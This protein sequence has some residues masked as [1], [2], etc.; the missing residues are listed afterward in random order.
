MQ[1]K[2]GIEISYLEEAYRLHQEYPFADAHFDLPAELEVRYARG[3]RNS[4]SEVYLPKWKWMGMR[5]VIASVFIKN[6]DLPENGM[7]K[8]IWQISLLLRELDCLKGDIILIKS[9]EQ[10]EQWKLDKNKIGMILYLEGLD[11][12]GERSEMLQCFYEIGVRGA[13]L[14][15]SRRNALAT[16]CCKATEHVDI[17]GSISRAG[18]S[19][20]REMERLGMFI[21]LSHLNDEGMYEILHADVKGVIATHSNARWIYN[22]YRNIT[23]EQAGLIVEKKGIIGINVNRVLSGG[24]MIKVLNHVSAMSLEVGAHNVCFG[25]DLCD[26]YGTG[27]R[28][29][30]ISDYKEC[31]YLTAGLIKYGVSTEN[32]TGI[33][34]RNLIQ[35]LDFF[36]YNG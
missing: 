29:D 21:D 20:I 2:Y 13:A 9:V 32:V 33:M 19:M 4:I 11:I 24:D 15:W 5:L 16:G 28:E 23:R 34:G 31:I 1:E 14:T 8:A 7:R 22:H 30:N 25:L 17:E 6:D 26:G 12:L 10:W 18:W 35:F 36:M 27:M 3:E